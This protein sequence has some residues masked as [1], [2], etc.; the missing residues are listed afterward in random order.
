MAYV[1]QLISLIVLAGYAIKGAENTSW[2]LANTGIVIGSMLVGTVLALVFAYI[3]HA[4]Q[5]G[6]L[7]TLPFST[8]GGFG[9][10]GGAI[11]GN[12]W[13]AGGIRKGHKV[14]YPP[15]DKTVI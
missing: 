13:R 2:K 7:D 15:S 4:E 11:A 3:V 14:Q 10:A 8:L 5:I 9:G 12:K 1:I 6:I